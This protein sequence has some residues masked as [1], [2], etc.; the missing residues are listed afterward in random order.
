MTDAMKSSTK[1]R[2]LAV[3]LLEASDH[4]FENGDFPGGAENLWGAA[5]HAITAVAQERGWAHKSRHDWK[6]AAS[7]LASERDDLLINASF[8]VA[9]KCHAYSHHGVI[10]DWQ[11]E[12]DRPLVRDFVRRVLG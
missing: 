1:H 7:R 8:A 2:Q 10:E 9:E 12:A 3:E 4:E 11:L 6:N 5:T